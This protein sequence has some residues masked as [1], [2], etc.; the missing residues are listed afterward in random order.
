M[1]TQPHR[2]RL[3]PTDIEGALPFAPSAKGG[4]FRPNLSRSLLS[5]FR[6]VS[7]PA[8]TFAFSHSRHRT[9]VL[10][11]APSFAQFA[12]GGLLRPNAATL[13]SYGFSPT[14]EVCP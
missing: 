4:L 13:F 10:E 12:K 14:T 3:C 1:S 6:G 5:F 8:R 11:G 2:D 7:T 9:T